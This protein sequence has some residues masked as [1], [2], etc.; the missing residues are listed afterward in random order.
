M[1]G[2]VAT[3]DADLAGTGYSHRMR[4]LWL[5]LLLA[6][7][8]DNIV[9][10][11]GA[12]SGSRLK[13]R[14]F[15]PEDGVRQWEA[16]PGTTIR[17]GHLAN[18]EVFYDEQLHLMCSAELWAD[19]TTRCTPP[20][21][22]TDLKLFGDPG[23]T[24]QISQH[25]DQFGFLGELDY[26]CGQLRIA[27]AYP[28]TRT[29]K[30]GTIYRHDLDGACRPAASEDREL[31]V[32]GDPVSPS[33]FATIVTSTSHDDE[34][35]QIRY[36]ESDDGM[37]LPIG[38][39]DELLGPA[40]LRQ[41]YAIPDRPA[42]EW[43][44]TDADCSGESV[45]RV[46]A[47]CPAPV[48]AYWWPDEVGRYSRV[49]ERVTPS[50]V[51]REGPTGCTAEPHE[52]SDY[53]R[54]IEE[55]LPLADMV[56]VPDEDPDRRIRV[57]AASTGTRRARTGV[58]LDTRFG[59]CAFYKFPDGAFRC[60]P[61]S[62]GAFHHSGMFSDAACQ[63]PIDVASTGFLYRGYQPSTLLLDELASSSGV[64]IRDISERY[65][66]PIYNLQEQCMPFDFGS[67]WR[68]VGRVVDWSE[69]VRAELVTE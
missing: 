69:L 4:G 54:I 64:E 63:V 51:Y 3:G 44:W 13:L 19:G 27:R 52:D 66:G 48:S 35:V 53:Y 14:W 46:E 49:A 32:L 40:V 21:E 23:C 30:F 58:L 10:V 7:C 55:R 11:D 42:Q 31:G 61:L 17:D 45:V 24:F 1:S 12:R 22:L 5:W 62:E 37:R 68:R 26:Q 39:Q 33:T 34:R 6:A 28:V 50:T 25:P 65:R 2:E 38:L 9:D 15:E 60:A 36:H 57:V 18:T 59:D 56:T 67:D 41:M 43:F 47:G 29:M 8:G 20:L 16:T